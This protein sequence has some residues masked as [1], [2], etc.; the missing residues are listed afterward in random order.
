MWVEAMH[1]AAHTIRRK[2]LGHRPRF[3]ERPV[4]GLARGVDDR[5]HPY[6]YFLARWLRHACRPPSR[7]V[8]ITATSFSSTTSDSSSSLGL[9]ER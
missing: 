2:S 8:E 1:V 7:N 6:T 3:E 9:L 4:D 5:R